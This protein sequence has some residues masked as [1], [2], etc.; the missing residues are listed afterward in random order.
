[1]DADGEAE[2]DADAAADAD[3]RGAA[4]AGD[5]PSP[6][7]TREI[8]SKALVDKMVSGRQGTQLCSRAQM[9]HQGAACSFIPA[10][11]LAPACGSLSVA[12][13]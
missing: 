3:L 11:V 9:P 7:G 13:S 8:L 6:S 12:P 4:Q 2:M 5:A 1:M 10:A